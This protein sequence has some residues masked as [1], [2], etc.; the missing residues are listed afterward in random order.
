[1]PEFRATSEIY[2][3]STLVAALMDVVLVFLLAKTVQRDRLRQLAWPLVIASALLGLGALVLLVR[4]LLATGD[5]LDDEHV[6]AVLVA[7]DH[8]EHRAS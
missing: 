4:E 2:W 3:I 8:V 1:M 7:P 6:G 5:A